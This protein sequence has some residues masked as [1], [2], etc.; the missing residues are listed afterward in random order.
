MLNSLFFSLNH[1]AEIKNHFFLFKNQ[2]FVSKYNF[3][4]FVEKYRNIMEKKTLYLIDAMAMIYRAYYALNK[5]PRINTKGLN[6]SAILGFCNTLFDIIKQYNPSHLGVAF[7]LQG[8]TF[9]HQQFEQ[10]KANRQAMPEEIRESLPHIKSIIEAMNIPILCKEG[11]EADDV[12]GTLSKKAVK[13]GFEVFM[14]TPDKDY[15]QLVEENIKMLRLGRLGNPNEVWGVEEVLQRFEIEKPIQVIDILGLWGDSSD[16]IPGVPTIG[17]KKAKALIQQFASIENIIENSEQIESKSIRKAI[18]EN[19]DI[20][21]QSKQLAT[22]ITDVPI[23]FDEES[24]KLTQPNINLCNQIFTDLEFNTFAKRFNSYYQQVTTT[25]TDGL[26]STTDTEFNLFTQTTCPTYKDVEHDY[27]AINTQEDLRK[28]I[29][30]LLQTSLIAFDTETTGLEMDCELIGISIVSQRHKGYFIFFPQDKEEQSAYI[31]IL[32]ELFENENI[33]KIA[34]NIKFDK[35][36]LLNY[37]I[38]VKGKTF[39]TLLAHY[40]LDPESRH[41]LDILSEKYLSYTMID[42]ETVFGKSTKTPINVNSLDKKLLTEYAVEDADITFALKP[43]LEQE[44]KD[45]Q[46]YELF[47]NIEMPLVD[48]LLGMERQGVKID[49]NQLHKFSQS[50]QEQKQQLEERIYELAGKEFNISSPKQLGVVLFDE[51]QI[52]GNQKIKK[53]QTKQYSTSEDVLQKLINLHPIIPLILEYRSLTKLKST[54]VDALPEI[55][56]TKTGKIHTHYKQSTT[57]TGRLASENPNLQN[58]PIRTEL[59]KQIRACFIPQDEEHI[60]LAADYSQIELRIIAS[61]SKD[62]NL[63]QAF[64][65]GEDIHLSTASRIYMMPAEDV[66]QDMRRNAKSVNFGIIY[67]ISAFGLSEQLHISRKE[68]QQLIE[69]YFSSYPQVKEYISSC[70]ETATNKG[71]AESICGRRR[72]LPDLNS[73]NANIRSFAQRNAVNM[74]IQASSADMIKIA[75]INI[76]KELQEKNLRSKMI[77]QVHDELV[78]DVYK[79]ELATIKSIVKQQMINALPLEIPI[80]V[81]VNEGENWLQAH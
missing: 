71:Y 32:K 77:L 18:E 45:N 7:D 34:H 12:I 79:P 59:G 33:E 51:L 58:I 4:N 61:L 48:V 75:M 72:Y 1:F 68:A 28:V 60:L 14:V 30:S 46:L 66:S 27:I 36:V 56:N 26:F 16:N 74:P 3:F 38:E 80:E 23:E 47:Q 55:V 44:L 73:A 9:R 2:F 50:L 62:P 31:K 24:L 54:Y 35:N 20:A 37:G 17:E 22:I 15:A 29:D 81:S 41:K 78:F 6:T 25:P 57:S 49:T 21:I 65:S 69:Q 8:P 76:H 52:T 39:D 67:G 10:Y 19:K 13:Q 70:I 53:T 11:F 43:I 63:C 40:L 64:L 42:F 5:N